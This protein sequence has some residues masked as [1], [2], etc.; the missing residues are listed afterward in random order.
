MSHTFFKRLSGLWK[1][2]VAAEELSPTI[3]VRHDRSLRAQENQK[4]DSL[5][6]F[7]DLKDPFTPSEI[8]GEDLPGPILS[9]MGWKRF[10][11]LFLFHTPHT[12]ERARATESEVTRR[13]PEQE[14]RFKALPAH[15]RED[16]AGQIRRETFSRL[17]TDGSIRVPA[18]PP[19][20]ASTSARSA[21]WVGRILKA[22]I[23]SSRDH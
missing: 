22:M 23:P 18:W 11:S 17:S 8:V 3:A 6:A 7:V 5:F 21:T 15:Y 14:K 9:V 19:G 10:E 16:G 4:A 13:F 1:H 12:K 2:D 20:G